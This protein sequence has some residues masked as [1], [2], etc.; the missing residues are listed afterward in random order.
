[1]DNLYFGIQAI[2]KIF[3]EAIVEE[4]KKGKEDK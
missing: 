2:A 1:M 3:A 4:M